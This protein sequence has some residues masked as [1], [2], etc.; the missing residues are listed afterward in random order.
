MSTKKLTVDCQTGPRSR[1]R[2]RGASLRIHRN[3]FR[4]FDIRMMAEALTEA[5]GP[6]FD[7]AVAAAAALGR[8][9]GIQFMR[10]LFAHGVRGDRPEGIGIRRKLR[11]RRRA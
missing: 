8:G 2:P 11:C 4:L 6:G 9:L 3:S 10:N 7:G 5:A 1:T